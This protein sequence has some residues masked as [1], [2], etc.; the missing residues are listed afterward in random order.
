MQILIPALSIFLLS[1]IAGSGRMKD[2]AGKDSMVIR[3][4]KAKVKKATTD[5]H[6]DRLSVFYSRFD[7]IVN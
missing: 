6:S 3:M 1:I 5:F 4:Q 7:T 2:I